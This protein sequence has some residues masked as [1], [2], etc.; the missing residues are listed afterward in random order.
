MCG[1]VGRSF[2][3]RPQ[4]PWGA[5]ATSSVVLHNLIV[6]KRRDESVPALLV[7]TKHRDGYCKAGTGGQSADCTQPKPVVV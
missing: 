3:G 4:Q 7:S 2:R 5:G 1:K 6:V